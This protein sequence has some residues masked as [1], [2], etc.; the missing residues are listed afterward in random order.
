MTSHGAHMS[1]HAPLYF[2]VAAVVVTFLLLGRYLEARAKAKAGGALRALLSLGAK[3]ATVLRHGVEVKI[4]A[5][6]LAVGE[7][8]VVR[9]GEKIATDGIVTDGSSAVDASL[10]TGESLPVEV[11][12]HDAVTGATINTTGR[13]LVRA[14]RVVSETA[15]AQMGRLVSEAQAGKAPIARLADRISAVF[16]PVVLAIA[17]LTFALWLMFDGGLQSAFTAAVA[18]LLIASARAPWAWP[19]RW[20]CSRARAAPRNWASSSRAPRCWRT[21]GALTR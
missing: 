11:A 4:P 19:P 7:V 14:T 20:V 8:F 17:L 12:P 21:P 13:L 2:E 16:V 1:G 5:A 6:E 3:E 15:L 10:L 18:V 9:P